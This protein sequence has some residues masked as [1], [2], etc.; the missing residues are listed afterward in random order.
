MTRGEAK[1]LSLEL[2]RY[3]E[4]NPEVQLKWNV[5]PELREKIRYL[6]HECP[7]CEVFESYCL[8][9]SYCAGCPMFEA[10]EECFRDGSAF[11]EWSHSFPWD[12]ERR[13]KA[14]HRIVEIVEA[15]EPEESE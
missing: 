6:N 13:K 7:L 12:C 4:E 10:G 5:P 14:A 9:K 2:W 15:W 1:A 8:F 11:K 3:L